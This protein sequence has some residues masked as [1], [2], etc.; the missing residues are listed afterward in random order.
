MHI[1]LEHETFEV[2]CQYYTEYIVN[3]NIPELHSSGWSRGRGEG[4]AP[5]EW[6]RYQ[7]WH[8]ES[9]VLVQD[10][11]EAFVCFCAHKQISIVSMPL[12]LYCHLLARWL[13][14]ISPD[15]SKPR[16][17]LEDTDSCLSRCRSELCEII[18]HCKSYTVNQKLLWHEDCYNLVRQWMKTYDGSISKMIYPFLW[19]VFALFWVIHLQEH[20]LL[21]HKA[22][23]SVALYHF[24]LL[25]ITFFHSHSLKGAWAVCPRADPVLSSNQRL[26]PQLPWSGLASCSSSLILLLFSQ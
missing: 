25:C 7:A 19:H 20:V 16:S 23:L 18:T 15:L 26:P 11:T 17:L 12:D 6:L 8:P 10:D 2:D 22:Y 9:R 4:K 3:D 13:L 1:C 14:A 5:V 21:T 24:N